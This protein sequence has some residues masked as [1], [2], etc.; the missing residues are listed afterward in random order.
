MRLT[1]VLLLVAVSLVVADTY[2]PLVEAEYVFSCVV[3]GAY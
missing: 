3:V 2:L 1:T